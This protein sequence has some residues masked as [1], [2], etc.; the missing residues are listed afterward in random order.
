V[1]TKIHHAVIDGISG[2]EIMG[3]LLDLSPEGRELPEATRGQR[4]GGAQRREMLARSVGARRAIRCGS[5]V[6]AVGRPRTSTTRR[7]ARCRARPWSAASPGHA[8]AVDRD[9]AALRRPPLQ[10]AEDVVQRAGPPHRRV[11]FGPLRSTR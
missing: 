2:A 6:A 4:A 3:I 5:C 11:A 10:V 8:G 1:L 9:R 7:C